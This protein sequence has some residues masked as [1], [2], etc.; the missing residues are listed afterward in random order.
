MKVIEEEA[1]LILHHGGRGSQRVLLHHYHYNTFSF[2][3]SDHDEH[4]R[5][6]MIDYDNWR[7]FLVQF[8]RDYSGAV[9]GIKWSL[10][11]DIPPV[12]LEREW[13]Q[14]S[15]FEGR[16]RINMEPIT[17]HLR[18]AVNHAHPPKNSNG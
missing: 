2:A 12:L 14:K 18:I 3:T 7:L 17:L 11:A 8:E 10:D 15:D 9:I 13:L 1:D 16:E 6:G 4:M 5:L